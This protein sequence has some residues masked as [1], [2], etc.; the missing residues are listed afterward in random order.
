[1]RYLLILFVLGVLSNSVFSQ[2]SLSPDSIITYEKKGLA[3]VGFCIYDTV[4][5]KVYS[6][7]VRK[8]HES[9]IF[10]N[11]IPID[12][13]G[14]YLLN[15][16]KLGEKIFFNYQVK[17]NNEKH[18]YLYDLQKK[19]LVKSNNLTSNTESEIHI[20]YSYTGLYTKEED[21]KFILSILSPENFEVVKKIDLTQYGQWFKDESGNKIGPNAEITEVIFLDKNS[22]LVCFGVNLESAFYETY[23]TLLVKNDEILDFSNKYDAS[24]SHFFMIS[25]DKK[26]IKVYEDD[27]YFIRDLNYSKIGKALKMGIQFNDDMI[28]HF[29]PTSPGISKQN[30]GIDLY[31]IYSKLLNRTKVIIP[32]KFIPQLDLAMYKA[33][34]NERL[35]KDDIKGLDL[36]ALGI[37]RNSIFAKYNYAFNSEFYQAYFNLFAFYNHSEKKGKRTKNINDKLTDTDKANVALILNA[38]KKLGN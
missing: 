20:D 12:S 11:D 10:I 18:Y 2:K 13:S 17:K 27:Q 25:N 19:D 23:K 3:N 24:W 9:Y 26:Y 22:F 16:I 7:S 33:H 15:P 14:L 31:F 35:T 36:Y 38:E 4:I 8:D 28:V 30:I 6:R 32:Y 21:D 29:L 1:M 34:Q 5:I 37:L